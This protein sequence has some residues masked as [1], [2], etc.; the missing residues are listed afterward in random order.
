[1]YRSRTILVV[2]DTEDDVFLLKRAFAKSGL[3]PQMQ[4]VGDGEEAVKYLTG[5][6]S[7]A[8]R[9]QHPLPDLVLLDLKMPR[10]DGFD[11]LKW[12]RQQ[13]QWKCLVVVAL[14]TSNEPGDI[15]K[16]Y[17]LRANSYLSKNQILG[18]EVQ[19]V[20]L[21]H[22]YWMNLNVCPPATN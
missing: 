6:G 16:A 20:S 15:R 13:P 4:I 11:V 1:M 2:E 18:G 5:S 12:L 17:E 10:M 14:S 9:L 22:H 19:V 3:N 8:D 7:Y 21:M